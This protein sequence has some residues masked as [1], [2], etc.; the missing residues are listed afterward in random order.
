MTI[1]CLWK[2]VSGILQWLS[3]SWEHSLVRFCSI[4]ENR[5]CS[6]FFIMIMVLLEIFPNQFFLQTSLCFFFFLKC[7]LIC[8]M[9]LYL[10]T[11][12][13][14]S[15]FFLNKACKAK[16]WLFPEINI[17]NKFCTEKTRCLRYELSTVHLENP[18]MRFLSLF[19]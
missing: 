13:C 17:K 15:V 14:F 19:L 8:Y 10:L 6:W 3:V 5:H 16:M 11:Y 1:L 18:V 7:D 2:S 4:M 9:L 12:K